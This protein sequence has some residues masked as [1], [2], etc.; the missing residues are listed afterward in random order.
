MSV[1]HVNLDL[2]D[3]LSVLEHLADSR[4]QQ[5]VVNA[6][7]ESYIDDTLDFIKSVHAFKANTGALEQSIGW[8][9]I[10]NGKAEV[11]ANADYATYVEEGTGIYAGH[12]E[13]DVVAKNR[14]ALKITIAGG[15]FVLHRKAHH[16]GAKPHP[17]FFADKDNREQHMQERGLLVLARFING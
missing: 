9:G 2:G 14:K 1:L 7:A 6:A 5:A 15:G 4:A 17:F 13:W 3:T 12:S 8:H 10:G 16:K 11:Y